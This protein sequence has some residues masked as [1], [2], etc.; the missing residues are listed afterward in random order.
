MIRWVAILDEKEADKCVRS[1]KETKKHQQDGHGLGMKIRTLAISTGLSM[2]ARLNWARRR[3]T[4][5]P[6]ALIGQVYTCVRVPDSPVGVWGAQSVC[7]HGK[8][9]CVL[10]A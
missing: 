9:C 5:H 2:I 7:L 3:H 1:K 8:T 4:V 6:T 10:A